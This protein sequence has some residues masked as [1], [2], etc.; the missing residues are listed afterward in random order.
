MIATIVAPLRLAVCSE[1]SIRGWLVPGFWPKMKIAFAVS[2]SCR[3]TEPLP[4]PMT[5][6]SA[7]PEDSWHRLLQS[8]RLLVP[9][10]RTNSWYRNAASF[11]VRPE[12]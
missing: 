6:V 3:W 9:K 8:G 2:R 1:V 11:D 10:R 4:E 5:S 7:T 12:V